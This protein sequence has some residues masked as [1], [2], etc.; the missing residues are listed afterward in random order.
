VTS[1]AV[2]PLITGTLL[3]GSSCLRAYS[4]GAENGRVRGLGKTV[5]AA[6]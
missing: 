5:S 2:P 3:I 4:G 6:S 1:Q